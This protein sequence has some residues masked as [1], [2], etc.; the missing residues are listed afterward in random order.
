MSVR[1]SSKREGN[2]DQYSPVDEKTGA[3]QRVLFSGESEW[4][5]EPRRSKAGDQSPRGG[6]A[7]WYG[8]AL[9]DLLPVQLA[10]RHRG[11]DLLCNSGIREDLH[12]R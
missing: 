12:D 9:M 8:A 3:V 11:C 5:S 1:P 10:N 6:A 4:V 7:E 2:I